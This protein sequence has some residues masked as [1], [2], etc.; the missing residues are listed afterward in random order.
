MK[1]IHQTLRCAT[2][3]MLERVPSKVGLTGGKVEN[4]ATRGAKEEAE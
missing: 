1:W 2:R 3:K 4:E